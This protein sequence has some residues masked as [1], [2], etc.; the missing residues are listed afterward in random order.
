MGVQERGRRA[1]ATWANPH[2]RKSETARVLTQRLNHRA[3]GRGLSASSVA[4]L[5]PFELDGF[6]REQQRRAERVGNETVARA[7]RRQRE[8]QH[9]DQLATKPE[10]IVH[11]DVEVRGSCGSDVHAQDGE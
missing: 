4:R 7:H 9:D 11:F 8:L 3:K 6:F 10:V 5:T 1:T 2:A